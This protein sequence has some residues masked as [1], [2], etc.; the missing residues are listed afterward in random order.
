M[1][2]ISTKV[3][4]LTLSVLLFQA[5]TVVAQVMAGY[6]VEPRLEIVG[7]STIN[8]NKKFNWSQNPNNTTP[9]ARAIDTQYFQVPLEKAYDTLGENPLLNG[10]GGYPDLH[11]KFALIMRG[12][13][14][15]FSQKAFYCQQAGAIG[16]IIVNHKNG[17]T[18][19]MAPTTPFSTNTTIPVLIISREDGFPINDAIKAGQTV[20]INLSTWGFG[21]ANDLGIVPYSP[22]VP[23][24]F[25]LPLSQV[26]T[27]GSVPRAYNFYNGAY[28]ANFGTTTQSNVKLKQT[29]S[30]TPTGGS[31][32]V[33]YAD[34]V[35]DPSF[36][37]ADSLHELFSQ[38][39]SRQSFTSNGVVD[40]KY[41]LSA[42]QPDDN[43]EDNTLD[44]KLNITDS[45]FCKGRWDDIRQAPL[46][47]V[48]YRY[49]AN[50]PLVW[51]PLFYVRKG[52]YGVVKAQL[53]IAADSDLFALNPVSPSVLVYLYKW[54]DNSNDGLVNGDELSIVAI[55]LRSTFASTD[56]SNK[57]FF[58]NLVHPTKPNMLPKL[59]DN[60]WYFLAAELENNFS[61]G[62]DN[63]SN[64]YTRS[65]LSTHVDSNAN[66]RTE[67]W[68]PNFS[69]NIRSPY[70]V[71]DDT[72]SN[73]SFYNKSITSAEQVQ[74][75]SLTGLVPAMALHITKEIPVSVRTSGSSAFDRLLVFPNPANDQ[76]HVALSMK[77]QGTVVVSVVN[78]L[79][80][81]LSFD[82]Y[83]NFREGQLS[84]NTSK[85]S[86][87][88]YYLIVATDKGSQAIK[89]SIQH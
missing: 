18:I 52:G 61:L 77:Q 59:D 40:M 55:G 31:S 29:I 69:G 23:H 64:F 79:G 11:G 72:L 27:P 21:F 83:K 60:S 86:S 53:A 15:S 85:F 89:F 54:N 32:S 58:V 12:G 71:P 37:V 3:L 47:S 50:Q 6:Y 75:K 20:K 14:I 10:T 87:G 44:Y 17:G 63:Y 36:P 33:V 38:N 25:C 1:T 8:G 35:L 67:Y 84:V 56:S 51:G 48:A 81:S 88:N 34:S 41:E 45:V 80:Q 16:V 24:A 82:T 7:S 49:S 76:V 46:V 73:I 78:T 4:F 26:N 65:V 43:I 42:A 68:A 74:F 57:P 30:F 70:S 62:A 5:A 13:G 19:G 22:A 28:V 39:V 9:W 66:T 2:R